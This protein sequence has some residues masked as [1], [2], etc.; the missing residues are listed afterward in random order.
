MVEVQATY[1][2]G[3]SSEHCNHILVGGKARNLW[4]LGQRVACPVPPWFCVT[5]EAF[6]LFVEVLTFMFVCTTFTPHPYV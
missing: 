1:V 3:P 6:S 2:V 5:T 4:L